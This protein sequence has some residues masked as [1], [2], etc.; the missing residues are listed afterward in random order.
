MFSFVGDT[1]LDPFLGTG[2]TSAA[3]AKW[4][5]NSIGIEVD[6]HYSRWRQNAS[7]T[8]RSSFFRLRPFAPITT[9]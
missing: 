2:T 8:N 9:R 1:V 5:R 4:G 7:A 3:A 6:P